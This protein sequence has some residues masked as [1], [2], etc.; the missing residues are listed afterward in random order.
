MGINRVWGGSRDQRKAERDDCDGRRRLVSDRGGVAMKN[1]ITV[2]DLIAVLRDGESADRMAA[3]GVLAAFGPAALPALTEALG[4]DD[5]RLKMWAAYTLGMLGDVEA[6]PPLTLALD[7]SD[8]G[9][10]KWAA[11]AIRWIRDGAGGCCGC[12]FW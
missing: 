10:V 5:P 2:A 6:I 7:D 3:A 1:S 8:P 9:V 4:D 11:A 12:R